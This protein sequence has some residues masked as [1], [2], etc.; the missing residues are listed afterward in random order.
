MYHSQECYTVLRRQVEHIAE[1][2]VSEIKIIFKKNPF[3]IQLCKVPYF[4]APQIQYQSLKRKNYHQMM[5]KDQL[6][7]YL[8][9][10]IESSQFHQIQ[11]LFHQQ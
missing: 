6:F 9:L 5:L 11:I 4:G 10:L 7:E 3:G 2:F 1:L 8:H